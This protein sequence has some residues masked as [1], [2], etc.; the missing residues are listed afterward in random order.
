MQ[1]VS[2]VSLAWQSTWPGPTGRRVIRD[3]GG[4]TQRVQGRLLIREWDAECGAVA[5][6][7]VSIR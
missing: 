4:G 1:D 6:R 3:D 2:D 7:L 5:T